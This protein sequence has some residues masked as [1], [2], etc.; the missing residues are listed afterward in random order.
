MPLS[1]DYLHDNRAFV[2]DPEYCISRIQE[3]RDQGIEYFGCNFA[4]G[5]IEHEKVMRSMELFAR[6]VMP[7]FV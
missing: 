4:F 2:G 5:G 1:Y 3:L 7:H 6:E